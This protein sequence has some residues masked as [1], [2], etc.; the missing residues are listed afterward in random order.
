MGRRGEGGREGGR[1]REGGR[2]DSK[3][4]TSGTGILFTETT[5]PQTHSL[6]PLSPHHLEAVW[7]YSQQ[8]FVVEGCMDVHV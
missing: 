1:E 2:G 4:R 3:Q 5:K 7:E 8:H 6:I